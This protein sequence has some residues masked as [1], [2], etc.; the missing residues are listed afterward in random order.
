MK[1][2]FKGIKR[3]LLVTTFILLLG[4]SA[5]TGYYAYLGYEMYSNALEE[6]SVLEMAADIKSASVSQNIL[7]CRPFM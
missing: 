4:A 5:V 2:M 6:K 7:S 3:I 1:K